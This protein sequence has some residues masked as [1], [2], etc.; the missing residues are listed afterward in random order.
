MGPAFQTERLSVFKLE[1]EIRHVMAHTLYIAYERN[2]HGYPERHVVECAIGFGN[3]CVLWVETR[4]SG[5]KKGL[6]CELLNGIA[7]HEE[8]AEPIYAGVA[9]NNQ[10]EKLFEKHARWFST[11]RA[12]GTQKSDAAK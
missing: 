4:E 9:Q 5:R 11:E 3:P 2:A 7:A 1:C 6:A 12:M 10:A 8:L